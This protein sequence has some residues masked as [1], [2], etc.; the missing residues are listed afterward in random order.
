MWRTA[1]AFLGWLATTLYAAQT[2]TDPGHLFIPVGKT[3]PSYNSWAISISINVASYRERINT[4]IQTQTD[5]KRL[6]SDINDGI[7]NDTMANTTLPSAQRAMLPLYANQLDAA[8]TQL[9][10]EINGLLR[11]FRDVL[12]PP[13]ASVPVDVLSPESAVSPDSVHQP[14]R[15]KRGLIDGLGNVMSFLFGTATESEIKH[16]T[17][18]V[19]LINAKDTALAHRFNGTLQVLNQTRI[20]TVQNRRALST[21]TAAVQSLNVVYA[22]TFVLVQ[23]NA[24]AIKTA[25][26]ITELTN[27]ILR[28]SQSVQYLYTELSAL[29]HKFA[30]AQAGILHKNLLPRRDFIRLL[31]KIDKSLPLNFALPFPSEQTT[32]YVRVVKTKLIEGADAYHV[33]FYIPL[34]HTKHAFDV[35]RFFPYQVPLLAHNVSLGY[36][37]NEPRYILMSENRQQFIQPAQ[38]EIEACILARQPFCPLHEPAYSTVGSTSCVAALFKRDA[39][40][41]HKYCTPQILPV[42]ASPKAYYLTGGQWLLVSRPPLSVTVFCAPTQTSYTVSII[43]SIDTFTLAPECSASGDSFYLPPYYA[44][45]THLELPATRPVTLLDVASLPIWRPEWSLKL[46]NLSRHN[47]SRLPELHI[48]GMPADAYFDRITAQP[49]EQVTVDSPSAFS[50]S[51]ILMIILGVLSFACLVFLLRHCCPPRRRRVVHIR[52]TRAPSPRESPEPAMELQES[53]PMVSPPP[54]SGSTDHDVGRS[55]QCAVH[56]VQP[57]QSPAGLDAS[58]SRGVAP[59]KP[60]QVATVLSGTHPT[61]RLS[62]M[63]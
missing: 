4:V 33:L 24:N 44:G 45:E 22:K 41:V 7:K 48:D 39:A 60:A 56:F 9:S 34:L 15:A 1:I 47:V 36:Y 3:Y 32:E 27:C 11:T 29:S 2:P 5:L 57:P 38:S 20:A 59:L 12:Y 25:M 37:P 26:H 14:G 28:V 18:N 42:P 61:P 46:S 8:Q 17:N 13:K 35:Y 19:E 50:K 52:S 53:T 10:G 63:V 23:A 31:R 40:S 54:Q 16:L 51:M 6:V 49:L 21:L 62:L 30:L 43:R 58:P 55:S